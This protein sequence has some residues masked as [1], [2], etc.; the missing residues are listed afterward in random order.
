MRRTRAS[1]DHTVPIGVVQ[2]L[3]GLGIA[4]LLPA[5]QDEDVLLGLRQLAQP[6]QDLG[7]STV[8]VQLLDHVAVEVSPVHVGQPPAWSAPVVRGEAIADGYG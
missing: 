7:Q 1:R 3:G 8:G 6:V 4:E 2:G 5:D